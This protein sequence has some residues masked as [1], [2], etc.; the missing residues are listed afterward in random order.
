MDAIELSLFVKRINAICEEMGSVLMRT[1]F[2]PN[3]KEP[4]FL[5]RHF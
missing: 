4:G 2:S 3:I 5:L 1:A